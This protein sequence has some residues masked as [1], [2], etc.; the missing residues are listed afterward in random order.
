MLDISNCDENSYKLKQCNVKC[1]NIGK[2]IL[3]RSGGGIKDE[4]LVIGW[5][6]RLFKTKK[7]KDILLP[8]M[9]FSVL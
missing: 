4:L 2:N 9:E 6:K 8:P 3:I 7:F 1:P 5:I